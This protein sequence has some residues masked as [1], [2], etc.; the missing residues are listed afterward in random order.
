MDTFQL[1]LFWREWF[2]S[3]NHAIHCMGTNILV[4]QPKFFL[5][6]IQNSAWVPQALACGYSYVFPLSWICTHFAIFWLCSECY[7]S[8]QYSPLVEMAMGWK[9][10]E[11]HSFIESNHWHSSSVFPFF[12]SFSLCIFLI[13]LWLSFPFYFRISIFHFVNHMACCNYFC[14]P[15]HSLFSY[16]NF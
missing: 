15:C 3:I 10:L 2:F 4:L 8:V 14:L 16:L 6:C 5:C 11:I 12:E 1:S 9:W 7:K 13:I